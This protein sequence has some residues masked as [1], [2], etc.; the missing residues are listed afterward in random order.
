M[1]NPEAAHILGVAEAEIVDVKSEAGWWHALHHDMASHDEN[2]RKVAEDSAPEFVLEPDPQPVDDQAA[3]E[4][5]VADVLDWVGDDP[6][7][8]QAA[9]DAEK[10][11]DAPRSTL[12][13]SLEKLVL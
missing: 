8:A 7:R 2:W 13:A 10:A 12:M 1:D 9:L 11:K 5:T 3:L 4:G 6:V